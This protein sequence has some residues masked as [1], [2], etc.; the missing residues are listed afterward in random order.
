MT[1]Q[2]NWTELN[3]NGTLWRLVGHPKLHKCVS[4]FLMIN[5]IYIHIYIYVYMC[6]CVCVFHHSVVSNSWWPQE[7]WATK[8]LCPWD[9]PDKNT[10]VG[11][12]FIQTHTHTYVYV[13]NPLLVL[14]LWRTLINTPFYIWIF[15][16]V[17][18]RTQDKGAVTP[19][20]TD[21]DLP[22]SV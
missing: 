18:T 15:G 13:C 5:Y 6:V 3:E 16:Y 10:R 21:P 19:Q 9:S 22:M 14:F 11:C 12:H 20:E 1:E 17:C 8:F 2:L 7:L 4:Q